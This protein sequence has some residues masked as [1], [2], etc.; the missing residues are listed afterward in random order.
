[1]NIPIEI[2]KIE[3]H[4]SENEFLDISSKQKWLEHI[5]LLLLED[6]IE[7][8]HRKQLKYLRQKITFTYKSDQPLEIQTESE[9]FQYQKNMLYDCQKINMAVVGELT[10]QENKLKGCDNNLD[11]LNGKLS[12]SAGLMTTIQ[13]SLY[14]NKIVF[15]VIAAVVVMCF[16]ILVVEKIAKFF[17]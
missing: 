13:R 14:R 5:D 3:E 7:M 1:M 4:L 15:F 10:R 2:I 8:H 12:V 9:V 6:N 17:G 16:S 11:Q